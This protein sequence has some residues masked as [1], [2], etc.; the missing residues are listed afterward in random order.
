MLISAQLELDTNENFC[1][2][3][4]MTLT[5]GLGDQHGLYEGL[6]EALD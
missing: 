1:V 4:E 3:Q 6:K 2:F 5:Y